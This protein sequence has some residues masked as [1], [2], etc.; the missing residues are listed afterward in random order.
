[1]KKTLL[2]SFLAVLI[3]EGSIEEFSSQAEL[4]DFVKDFIEESEIDPDYI[5][6]SIRV[7]E[8]VREFDISVE[9]TVS[10]SV[11]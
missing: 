6:D 2:T 5:S 11:E 8:V 4:T 1:M 7:F 10:V 3:E 9:N